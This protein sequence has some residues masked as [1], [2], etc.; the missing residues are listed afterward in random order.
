MQARLIAYGLWLL[1][2]LPVVGH[3][4]FRGST[5]VRIFIVGSVLL[6]WTQLTTRKQR[7]AQLNLITAA[8]MLALVLA[9]FIYGAV[10]QEAD[11]FDRTFAILGAVVL[12]G[13]I[14]YSFVS[15]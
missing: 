13:A 6:L 12:Y 3:I 11:W 15:N 10:Q 5:E 9:A 8:G 1:L 2:A 7:I 14:A 4:F